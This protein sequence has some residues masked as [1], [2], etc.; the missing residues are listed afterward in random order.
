MRKNKQNLILFPSAPSPGAP[1]ELIA[2]GQVKA[3]AGQ[4]FSNASH[5]C[6]TFE[7]VWYGKGVVEVDGNFHEVGEGDLYI[8]P[9][10]KKNCYYAD[11]EAPWEKVF[12]NVRGKAV[13]ALLNAYDLDGIV[14][15]PKI[16]LEAL[17]YFKMILDICGSEGED[18]HLDVCR[19]FHQLIELIWKV[20]RKDENFPQEVQSAKRF[21]DRHIE[22]KF[23]IDGLCSF[24]GCSHTHA[25]RTFKKALGVT[26]YQYLMERR[27]ETAKFYLGNTSMLIKDISRRLDF[28]DEFY[29]SN[30]FKKRTGCSPRDYRHVK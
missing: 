6:Y 24:M 3:F 7:Y 1:L 27:F 11:K 4:S 16:G 26:P 13:S 28:A 9:F 14:S 8:L 5:R 2:A 20:S 12:F 19:T 29:F 17:K 21:L 10:G 30:A 23:S 25:I 22:K 18:L 15:V